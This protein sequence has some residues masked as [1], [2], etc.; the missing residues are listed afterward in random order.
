MLY[1]GGGRLSVGQSMIF[2]EGEETEINNQRSS[3][4]YLFIVY[5]FQCPKQ[6]GNGNYY[7]L[8]DQRMESGT[9]TLLVLRPSLLVW[10]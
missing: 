8:M 1:R 3:Q 6:M 4:L 2:W 7:F 5:V 10:H 9:D